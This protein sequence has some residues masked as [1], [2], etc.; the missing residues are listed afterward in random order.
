MHPLIRR[1]IELASVEGYLDKL[2][3]IYDL[4]D[5]EPRTVSKI[6]LKEITEAHFNEDPVALVKGL[7]KL[8]KFPIDDI[9]VGYLRKDPSAIDRNPQTVRRIAQRLLSMEIED[10]I[11]LCRQ[12]KVDNRRMGE[13]FHKWFLDLGYPRIS[14][15]E[16]LRLNAVEDLDGEESRV[17]MLD[18]TRR[19]FRDFANIHL[20]CGLEKELDI[21]LKVNGQYIIGE[22]KYFSTYGGNQNNQFNDAISLIQSTQGEAVRIAILDGVV[23]LNTGDKMCR[24]IRRVESIAMSAL[25]LPEFINEMAVE[26][27]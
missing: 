23:W 15:G 14:E 16:L 7:L 20:N 24:K 2:L 6:T 21:L 8:K 27:I 26:I 19:N 12:P 22:A 5:V 3:E 10:L 11:K 1:S 17:L 25:L 13:L 4:S 9:F 18:G